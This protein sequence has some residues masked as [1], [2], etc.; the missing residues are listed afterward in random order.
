MLA[1]ILNENHEREDHHMKN[2]G[3]THAG[4]LL[5]LT[6]LLAGCIPVKNVEKAWANAE[7][8]DALAGTWVDAKGGDAMV[9]FVKT[10]QDFLVT[11]GTDGLE[12]GC[13]SITTNGHQYIIVAKFRAA[14]L[15][16]ENVDDD[17][18]D[19]TLLRYKVEGDK[20]TMYTYNQDNINTAVKDGKVAGEMDENDSASLKELDEATIAWLGKIGDEEKGWDAKHYKRK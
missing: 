3:I 6:L 18:K 12:G 4:L 13:R 16:F 11:T 20:L 1:L 14:I 10:D 19:A 9:G 17:T 2:L 8:D 7:A 15:G 5:G